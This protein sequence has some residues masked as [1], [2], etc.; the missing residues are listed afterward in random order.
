MMNQQMPF[1]AAFSLF[2]NSEKG[3]PKLPAFS[4]F[5]ADSLPESSPNS[6]S[7]IRCRRTNLNDDGTSV[8]LKMICPPFDSFCSLGRGFGRLWSDLQ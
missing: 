2:S 7:L 8:P 4:S 1:K 6:R 3:N 5:P